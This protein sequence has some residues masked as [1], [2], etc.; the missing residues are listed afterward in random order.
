MK[1]NHYVIAYMHIHI[2]V[3]INIRTCMHLHEQNFLNITRQSI[4][5]PSLCSYWKRN[6]IFILKTS[7]FIDPR[8]ILMTE[9]YGEL[10][11]HLHTSVYVS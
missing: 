6:G 7:E 8:L 3:Y 4:H 5:C 11:V 10:L 2:F 1:G 9:S